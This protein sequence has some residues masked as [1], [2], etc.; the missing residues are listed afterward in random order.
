MRGTGGRG[1]R[2]FEIVDAQHPGEQ[3]H[4]AARHDRQWDVAAC[5]VRRHGALGAVAADRGDGVDV[6]RDE[7]V[8]R[9]VD[10]FGAVGG[11]RGDRTAVRS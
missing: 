10:R 3:V 4:R 2:T 9:I 7:F 8:D 1:G 11:G 5:E 6:V